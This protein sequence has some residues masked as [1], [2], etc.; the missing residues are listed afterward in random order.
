MPAAQM[1]K[2]IN[3]R[4]ITFKP[5]EAPL[6]RLPPDI[7]NAIK[8]ARQ[9]P[10]EK[11]APTW[12]KPA[13]AETQ[14]DPEAAFGAPDTVVSEGVYGLPVIVHCCLESQ[15]IEA[16]MVEPIPMT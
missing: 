5:E 16:P 8:S 10:A 6:D 14:G 9:K 15:S 3:E 2:E 1:V 12:Y 7:A 13:A 11:K 4:G